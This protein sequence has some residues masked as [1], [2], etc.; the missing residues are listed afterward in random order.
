MKKI[1][2][3]LQNAVYITELFVGK[4][5][6]KNHCLYI[7]VLNM[8]LYACLCLNTARKRESLETSHSGPLGV[9]KGAGE[10]KR[11]WGRDFTLY[12]P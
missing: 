3:R 10:E 9:R 5:K 12:H 6:V 7:Y 4:G 11:T 8:D 1:Q 2:D